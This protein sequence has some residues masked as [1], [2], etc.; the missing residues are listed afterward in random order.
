MTLAHN[1]PAE[2]LVDM[3]T[4]YA[5]VPLS[6]F[7]RWR[8]GTQQ[9]ATGLCWFLGLF[10]FK[11]QFKGLDNFPRDGSKFV[12]VANHNS[13]WDPPMLAM[14]INAPVAFMAKQELFQK[15]PSRWMYRALGAFAVNRFKVEKRTIKTALMVLKET[16]WALALFPEGTRH[17]DP[18]TLGEIK[19]GA[20]SIARMAKVPIVPVGISKLGK[21]VSFVVG[22]LLPVPTDA[23]TSNALLTATLLKLKLEAKA[24]IK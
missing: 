21:Q 23:E 15:I 22:D 1:K 8:Y 17:P 19:T 18:D 11:Y 12:V 13:N 4:D 20:V 16:T 10:W 24:L 3:P 7:T 14:I 5:V 2:V 9:L 6:Y